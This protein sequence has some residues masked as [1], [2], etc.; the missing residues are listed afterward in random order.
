MTL[1]PLD[2]VEQI[3]LVGDSKWLDVHDLEVD[4]NGNWLGIPCPVFTATV[5]SEN[6]R[7]SAVISGPTSSITAV[8]APNIPI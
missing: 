4:V 8:F 6:A 2:G 7:Q 3:R 5:Y 1:P